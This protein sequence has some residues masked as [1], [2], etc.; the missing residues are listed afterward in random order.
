MRELGELN[1]W[2]WVT[3]SLG[4]NAQLGLVAALLAL[5]SEP[6]AAD[7]FTFR[8][9]GVPYASSSNR[10]TVQ[11]GVQT[12]TLEADSDREFGRPPARQDPAPVGGQQSPAAPAAG[13]EWFW[14]GVSPLL[15]DARSGRLE[16]AFAV[17]TDAPPGEV[18]PP[19][20]Q[21]LQ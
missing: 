6:V 18:V 19:Q 8:R 10:I 14:A 5:A 15:S 20:R 7:D 12:A 9:V 3:R 16:E 21:S 17:I 1:E 2:D 13:M 11:I 4:R